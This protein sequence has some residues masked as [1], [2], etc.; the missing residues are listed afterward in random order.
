MSLPKF[1]IA[2]AVFIVTSLLHTCCIHGASVRQHKLREN[3]PDNRRKSPYLV[4][5]SDMVKALEYIEQLRQQTNDEEAMPDYDDIEKFR[6]M[7]RLAPVQ[8]I[9]SPDQGIVPDARATW[10]EDKSQ[11]LKILLRSLQR[12]EKESKAPPTLADTRYAYNHRPVP[13]EGNPA[14][15][16]DDYRDNP[17]PERSKPLKKYP[18][19]FE[20]EDSRESPYKRTNENVEEQYTPQSLATLESVF[21]ELGKLSTPNNHKRDSLN[22]DQKL[23][24]DNDDDMY[25]V[26][27]LAYEDV[28]GGED[29]TPVE[30]KVETETEEVKNSREEFDR[31]SEETDDEVKRSS[32]SK[33]VEKADPDDFTKLV[34]Y[35]LLRFLEQSER[36]E[37][38]RDRNDRPKEAQ[39]SDKRAAR[40][41]GSYDIDPQAIYQLIEISRKLQIPPEDLIEMLKSGEIKKQDRVL[42]TEVEPEV[43]EDL[44]RIEEK[45]SQI[46]SYSKD[47]AVNKLY[48][49]RL[50]E[51]LPNDIPDDLTTDE[52][53]NILGLESIGN[54]NPKYILKQMQSKNA[55][56]RFSPP[57]A[58]RGDYVM[59]EPSALSRDYDKRRVDYDEA[60]DED[61]LATYL[62]AKMLTK[63]PKMINKLD[64]KRAAQPS[65]KEDQVAYGTYEQAMKDYFDQ[66]SSDNTSPAKR[67]S[68]GGEMAESPQTQRLDEDM[69]LKMLGYL[70]QETGEN[71]ERD[72]YGKKV[73]GM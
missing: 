64:L 5:N 67:L 48:N 72:V 71:E 49:R 20:D 66:I 44:D 42:Q 30:E 40:P 43:P 11:W 9:E 23:Y 4:P 46:S 57:G 32:P 56:S 14:A 62:A 31:D 61:E 47:K 70:N 15:D 36:P 12:A 18:L 52:I 41:L 27:N 50:P 54:Q 24:R 22:E 60:T 58:R 7:L 28:A 26:N 45:L 37:D 34:D 35:Y 63:Y 73:N 68:E 10:P 16:L 38:K 29:W 17:L 19:L 3:E 2:G 6:S 1:P 33:Y 53:L 21:E 51:M 25:R 8:N 55:H 59:A 65:S 69:L 39:N 13:E